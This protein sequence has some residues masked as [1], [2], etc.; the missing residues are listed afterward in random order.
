LPSLLETAARN[1]SYR[2]RDL[3]LFELRPVFIPRVGEEL[4]E[5][6]LRLGVL[7]CGRREPD[8]WAQGAELVDFF[9][10]KGIFEQIAEVLR[11]PQ[12]RWQMD[13][14]ETYLHP[15]K[16]A[17]VY[18]RNQRLGVLGEVHPQTLAAFAIDVPLY[19]AEFDLESL[20][21]VAGH[22]SGI[23]P[24]S[25]FPDLTRDSALLV[26][27]EVSAARLFEL[28]DKVKS[29]DAEEL[30]LFDLYR[31][32]GID[33][34]LKS[35]AIRVRYRSPERTLTDEEVNKAHGRLVEMLCKELN[36]KIR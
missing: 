1:L 32:K 34:G 26:A 21:K 8:G 35:M 27:E 23:K 12:L 15:G 36:A 5:E 28:F 3:R 22:F 6:P 2:S 24:L 30:I 9:D 18:S 4:P 14:G 29:K 7:L 13:A 25:R 31:G 33:P 16:S 19:V 17:V 20:L 10:L 11:V